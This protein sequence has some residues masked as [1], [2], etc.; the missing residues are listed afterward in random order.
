MPIYK[1]LA[2][3]EWESAQRLG[4]FTG[5][6]LDQRDGYIHFSTAAQVAETARLHFRGQADLVVLEVDPSTLEDSLKWEPSRGGAL[7]PHLYRPLPVAAVR[8]VHEAPLGG[9]GVPVIA[10]AQ[11]PIKGAKPGSRFREW[12]DA[13]EM[14]VVPPGRFIMGSPATEEGRFENEG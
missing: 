10:L 14:I 11:G 3:Q 5:S 2:R 12:P 6:A 8:A 13:P 1:I 9:D 7:F 4:A